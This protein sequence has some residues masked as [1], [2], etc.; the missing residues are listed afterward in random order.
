[1]TGWIATDPAGYEKYIGHWSKHL[2]P[3]F[4]EFA[5]VNS[6]EHVLDVGCGTGNLTAALGEANVAAATGIDVSAPYIAYARQRTRT[7][8]TQERKTG[9][10]SETGY[11]KRRIELDRYH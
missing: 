7:R 8:L 10:D 9:S 5:G 4:V 3:M 1:M 11:E 6:G 2:A